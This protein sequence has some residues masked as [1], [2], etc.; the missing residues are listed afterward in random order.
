MRFAGSGI[1]F[2]APTLASASGGTGAAAAAGVVDIGN[3][4]ATARSK[5]PRFDEL[6]AMAMQANSEEKQAGLYAGAQVA[7]AGIQSFGQTHGIALQE[8]ARLEAAE[9]Y[10]KTQRSVGAMG[11]IGGIAG[12]GLKLLTG[13][14]A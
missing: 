2:E 9:E 13:G 10:G 11:A 8:K 3:A 1:S 12:V 5:A 4:F 7:G 6:S 14:L